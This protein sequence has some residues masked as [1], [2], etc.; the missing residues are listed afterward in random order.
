[1]TPGFKPFTKQST[2]NA[3]W[4]NNHVR[5]YWNSNTTPRFSGHFSIFRLVFFVLKFLLGIARQ[6][7]LEKFAI[8][9]LKPWSHVRILIYRT[10]ATPPIYH[11]S[12]AGR[13]RAGVRYSSLKK[14]VMRLKGL[15]RGYYCFRSILWW[16]HYY[17]RA[18]S[19]RREATRRLPNTAVRESY[20]AAEWIWKRWNIR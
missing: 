19:W 2:A 16:S 4:F 11:V 20:K 14:A 8:L 15:S 17:Q 12:E 6:W 13:G 9:T 7:S 5:Y 18:A 3:L 1:M 10:R